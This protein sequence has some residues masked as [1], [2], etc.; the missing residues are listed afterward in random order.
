VDVSVYVDNPRIPWNGWIMSHMTADT[1]EELHS[2]AQSIGLK[3]S[4]FQGPPDHSIHHYDVTET[5]RKLAIKNGAVQ[6]DWRDQAV[7]A[8]HKAQRR[9][10]R[11]HRS[12]RRR[13]VYKGR[14]LK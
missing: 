9:R 14:R 3:R 5:K 12:A 11:N 2:M 6:E 10:N 13:I 8:R 4:W 1:D 7:I